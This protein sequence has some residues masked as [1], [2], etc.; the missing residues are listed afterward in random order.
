VKSM[1]KMTKKQAGTT[2]NNLFRAAWRFSNWQP[3]SS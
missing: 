2:I 3:Y 1:R